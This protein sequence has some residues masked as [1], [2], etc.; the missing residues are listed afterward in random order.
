MYYRNEIIGKYNVD[1]SGYAGRDDEFL[2]MIVTEF[3]KHDRENG[4]NHS[5]FCVKVTEILMR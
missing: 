4:I 2:L 3:D 5:M 1:L